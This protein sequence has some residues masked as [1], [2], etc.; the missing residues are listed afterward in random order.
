MVTY[1]EHHYITIATINQDDETTHLIEQGLA[2]KTNSGV[3]QS[4]SET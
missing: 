3:I 4:D 2:G 1:H